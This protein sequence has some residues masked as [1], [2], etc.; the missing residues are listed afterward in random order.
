M[1]SALR[2]SFTIDKLSDDTGLCIS[3]FDLADLPV[4]SPRKLFIFVMDSLVCRVNGS[5]IWCVQFGLQNQCSAL[6]TNFTKAKFSEGSSQ[7]EIPD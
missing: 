6:R 5:Q 1:L 4:R 3:A 2:M 7:V